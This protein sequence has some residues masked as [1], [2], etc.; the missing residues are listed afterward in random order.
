MKNTKEIL[1]TYT[2][3]RDWYLLLNK[4]GHTVGEYHDIKMICYQEIV[5]SNNY[6]SMPSNADRYYKK[7]LKNMH[8]E[9]YAKIM[10]LMRNDIIASR[11][12]EIIS[13]N[14]IIEEL[15]EINFNQ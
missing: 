11:D 13:L 6:H 12:K 4:K 15:K 3:F 14:S 2:D 10:E 9:I 5:G 8:R 7:A 1:E